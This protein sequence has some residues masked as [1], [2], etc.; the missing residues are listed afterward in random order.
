MRIRIL[1]RYIFR[2]V[3]MTFA[4]GICAFS[5]VFIGSGTLFRIAQYITDYGASFVSVL[6]IFI[7]SL[8]GIV[9]WTFPMSMLLA[10]LLTFGRLSSTSEVTAMKSCGIGFRRI[11]MPAIM[12]G[13]FVSLFAIAF[14][15]YTV[16]WANQAY[17]N[18]LYYEIQ[19][20]TAPKSQEHIIIKEI[21][22]GQIQRLVYARRYDAETE[23]MQGVTMQLFENGRVSHVENA[24][25]AEW[26]DNEWTMH[27]GVIYDVSDGTTE[28]TM[29]FDVQLLPVNESPREIVR[30]Q[31]KPEELTMKE[32]RAQIDIMR[33]QYVD[34]KKLETELYQRFTIPM[35][36]LI[37]ALIGIPMGLQPNR[38]SSSSG[39]A[40]SLIIIFS[41]YCMMTI[42]GAIAQSGVINPIYAVWMPNIIGLIIGIY[43]MRRAA[44]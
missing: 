3:F 16:P 44:R 29:H 35:A 39:F 41:Y 7:F 25:Y 14:N 21:D 10:S 1:D 22:Q 33:S 18:V 42:S 32:L 17:N 8:P 43:L 11:A 13:F 12:L 27:R 34:T 31:K 26:K 23:T 38:R 20:N 24:E 5:A 30:E 6:K 37:F 40:Y 15:E 19:G 4:F 36:S 2:E 28:H 9:I